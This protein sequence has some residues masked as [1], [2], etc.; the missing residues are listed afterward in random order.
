MQ[1]NTQQPN[2]AKAPSVASAPAE[3]E[4]ENAMNKAKEN[5]ERLREL[6]DAAREFDNS[7][8]NQRNSQGRSNQNQ[9]NQAGNNQGKNVSGNTNTVGKSGS[10]NQ[11][12]QRNTNTQGNTNTTTN[13]TSSSATP[14]D[15]NAKRRANIE[16]AVQNGT[17]TRTQANKLLNPKAKTSASGGGAAVAKAVGGAKAGS[18]A[19]VVGGAKAGNVAKAGS[20][21]K[22]AAAKAGSGPKAGVGITIG[23]ASSSS[24]N[25]GTA[26]SN[27]LSS[28]GVDA[29][30]KRPLSSAS[31][32][33]PPP[34]R[35]DTRVV[36]ECFNYIKCG[37]Q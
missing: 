6:E 9:T 17:I 12:T 35:I 29:G 23:T 8:S 7:M 15:Q 20:G 1:R 19:K 36:R 13:T 5:A 32:G 18:G 33:M 34:K 21:P 11:N 4:S 10:V 22:P 26:N 27:T 2:S 14:V 3:P 31:T 37:Y 28:G 30:K 24:S 16:K 25:A